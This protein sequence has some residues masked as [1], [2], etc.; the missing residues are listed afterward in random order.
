MQVPTSSETMSRDG[1]WDDFTTL[2]LVS[3][4]VGITA[5]IFTILDIAANNSAV[6]TWISST[7]WSGLSAKIKIWHAPSGTFSTSAATLSTLIY[8]SLYID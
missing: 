6:V 2:Q 7:L 1:S 3:S 5:I 8:C 4:T